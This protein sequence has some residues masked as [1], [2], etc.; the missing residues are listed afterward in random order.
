MSRLSEH[1]STLRQASLDT[2]NDVEFAVQ[3]EKAESA[4]VQAVCNGHVLFIAGNGGSAGE[5]Q[6]FSGEI[7]GR[8][9]AHRRPWGAIAL[10]T[11]SAVIT[12]IGNDYSFDEIFARQLEALGKDGDVLCVLSTSGSSPNILA[13]LKQAKKMNITTIGL[14][15]KSGGSMKE[16]LDIPLIVKSDD[17][18][19][20]QEIHLNV[21]H[22]IS[23][24]VD[25]HTI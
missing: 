14:G 16:L 20:I 19:R 24:A 7:A 3:Y 9:K 18:P 5:V 12:C 2:E 13:V 11:D 21:I 25:D 1:L 15:G 8:Y 10:T 6:H 17:T 22:A 23:E 4:V